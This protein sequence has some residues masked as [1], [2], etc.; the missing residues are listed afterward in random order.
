MTEA[1][2]DEATDGEAGLERTLAFARRFLALRHP[3]AEAAV[4][5]G[6]RARAEAGPESDYDLLLLF[7]ALPEGAWRETTR[8]EGAAFEVFAHDPGTFAYF[9]RHV[10]RASGKPVMAAGIGE[11]VP[12]LGEGGGMLRRARAL[13]RETLA[14][15]P[16]PLDEAALRSNRHVL[17]GLAD[18]LANRPS[19]H[20][21]IA[22]AATLY[23]LLAEFALRAAGRWSAVSKGLPRALER[24]DAALAGRFET[25]FAALFEAGDAAP[26][27]A[28]VDA[29][30]APHGSRLRESYRQSFPPAWRAF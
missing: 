6:S 22:A 8:F 27:L 12:V 3:A 29:L 20:A 28:L 10:D 16:L 14:A 24:Y 2:G 4:L 13:A 23:P 7:P 21:A 18:S 17:T 5:S 15:G 25:A 26:V 19:R 9:C 30:L 11:G 1:V